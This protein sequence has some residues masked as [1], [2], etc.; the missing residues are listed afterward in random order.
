LLMQAIVHAAD[1]QDRDGG[2]S[3]LRRLEPTGRPALARH[4]DRHPRVDHR[5]CTVSPGI[6]PPA[7]LYRGGPSPFL[8]RHG[9]RLCLGNHRLRLRAAGIAERRLEAAAGRNN[10]TLSEAVIKSSRASWISGVVA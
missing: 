2:V 4:V 7:A 6:R 9:A 10:D 1:I 8:N 3:L 5:S